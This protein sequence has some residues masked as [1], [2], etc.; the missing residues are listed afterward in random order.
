VT[1]LAGPKIW[2]QETGRAD[3]VS[4]IWLGIIQGW[5]QAVQ[6]SKDLGHS[7]WK[8]ARWH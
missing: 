3:T 4:S 2:G 6:G 7:S 1:D 8:M 5:P